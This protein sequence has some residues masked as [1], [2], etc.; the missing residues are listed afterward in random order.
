[1][2]L[3]RGQASVFPL[4]AYSL[5]KSLVRRIAARG[6]PA[7]QCLHVAGAFPARSLIRTTARTP[8]TR[9]VKNLYFS[10]CKGSLK[11][12]RRGPKFKDK[13]CHI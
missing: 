7:F 10:H 3:R 12:A 4:A 2:H 5:P 8:R 13:M 6:S 9:S 11:P 1:M